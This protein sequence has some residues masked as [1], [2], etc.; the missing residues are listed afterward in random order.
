MFAAFAEALLKKIK[1]TMTNKKRVTKK[2][3]LTAA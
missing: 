2:E 1:R 3:N